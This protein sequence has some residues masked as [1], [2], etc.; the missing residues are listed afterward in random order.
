MNASQRRKSILNILSRTNQPISANQLANQLSVSRQVI[1]GDVALLRASNHDILSTPRGYLLS[2]NLGSHYFKGKLACYHSAKDTETE[3]LLITN[4]GGMIL[5]VEIEHPVYGMLTAN[6]NIK[7]SDDVANFIEK[8]Q[9]YQ[10]S[11][12]STL[13]QGVHLHTISCPSKEAFEEIKE[14][15]G[16]HGFLFQSK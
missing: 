14:D 4:K 15:L 7:N 16:K 12:L 8:M 2:D 1:V 10:A 3:L 11:L 5:D 6:L 13:T 9:H